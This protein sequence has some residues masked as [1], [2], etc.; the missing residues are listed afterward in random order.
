MTVVR[1]HGPLRRLAGGVADHAVAAQTVTGV[2]RALE[3]EQPA[4]KGWMLDERG[5]IRPHINVF[6]NGE[7]GRGETALQERDRVEVLPA[8]SGG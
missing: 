7:L 6:V 5:L 1:I 8:I 3:Q 4:L 2:L